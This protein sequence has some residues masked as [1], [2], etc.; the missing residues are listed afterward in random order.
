MTKLATA[1][2]VSLVPQP[3][4]DQR[5]KAKERDHR[6]AKSAIIKAAVAFCAARGAIRGGIEADHTG[7]GVVANWSDVAGTNYQ[8]AADRALIKL[9]RLALST[10]NIEVV[11]LRSL[12]T[13]AER[14][15]SDGDR[16]AFEE[17]ETDFLAA[18]AKAVSVVCREIYRAE[19]WRPL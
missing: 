6:E 3:V 19:T 2:V 13:V 15:I 16:Q 17:L 14:I 1:K 10:K 8:D 11:E 18:F 9:S 5:T 7:N 4:D 12:A